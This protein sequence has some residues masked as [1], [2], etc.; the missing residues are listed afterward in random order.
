MTRCVPGPVDFSVWPQAMNDPQER[1]AYQRK[2]ELTQ[3]FT[4]P[5]FWPR[6]RTAAKDR[7]EAALARA[8]AAFEQHLDLLDGP[9][10]AQDFVAGPELTAADIVVGHVLY[11]W[12]DIDV[13]RKPRPALEAYYARL[14][15]RAAFRDHV[16]V[17]FSDLRVEGA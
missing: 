8:I 2:N 10:G 13:P 17:D 11:R 1:Y 16:M 14:K 12:F 6:V 15:A 4:L 5:I 3:A 9:L 7:D